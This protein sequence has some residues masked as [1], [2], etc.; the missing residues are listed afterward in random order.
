MLSLLF[1][2]DESVSIS[3]DASMKIINNCEYS[4]KIYFDDSYIGR[5]IDG[6][7]EIWS[8]PVGNHEVK[9]VC[10][11][12]DDYE[13]NHDFYAD[14]LTIITLSIVSKYKSKPTLQSLN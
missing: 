3:G 14:Q 12:S 2:C 13:A 4:V 1:S 8:V 11:F 6:E 10:S 9:A 7:N 5:V